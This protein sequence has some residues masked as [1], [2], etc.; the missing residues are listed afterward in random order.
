MFHLHLQI[1]LFHRFNKIGNGTLVL[2]LIAKGFNTIVGH[3]Q[4]PTSEITAQY[5]H[6]S[7]CFLEKTKTKMCQASLFIYFPNIDDVDKF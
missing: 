6:I 7:K 3:C 4:C 5:L 1:P 2:F